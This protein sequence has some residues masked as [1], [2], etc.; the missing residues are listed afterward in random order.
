MVAEVI[1][2]KE[3]IIKKLREQVKAKISKHFK[4]GEKICIKLHMGEYGNLNYVRPPIIELIVD[5]LKKAGCQPFLFDSLVA[6]QG[7]R[8][9]VRGALET[10]RKHGFSKET[11]GCPII[12]SNEGVDSDTIHFSK[13]EVCKDIADANGMIVVSHFKAHCMAGYG[14][15][16]KNLGMGGVP[17]EIKALIHEE[18]E[19]ELAYP[20]KCVSCGTCV[21]TCPIKGVKLGKN[22]KPEFT[23]CWGC[24]ACVMKCPTKALKSKNEI[25][26]GAGLAESAMAVLGELKENKVFYINVLF[27]ISDNC[28]CEPVGDTD[29]PKVVMKNLGI[30]LSEDIVAIDKA[31]F[32]LADTASNM[33]FKKIWPCDPTLQFKT[34]EDLKMG[35]TKYKIVEK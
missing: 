6:Y 20:E 13:M 3:R 2:V 26:L 15:A 5:E 10:A 16:I 22:N 32:D 11:M 14:A 31:A 28:D 35:S 33:E 8:S 30:L 1:L 7:T 9:T 29:S 24:G 21:R 23:S 18:T 27:D 4:A 34:A 17:K 12:V 25:A 19:A